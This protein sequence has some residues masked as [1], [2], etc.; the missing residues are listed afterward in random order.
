MLTGRRARERQWL[1]R[2]MRLV[3]SVLT[4]LSSN[5]RTRRRRPYWPSTVANSI[6][7]YSGP[8]AGRLVNT[9]GY[10]RRGQGSRP[11]K[12]NSTQRRSLPLGFSV[13]RAEESA[14]RNAESS[15]QTTPKIPGRRPSTREFVATSRHNASRP[16]S[17]PASKKSLPESPDSRRANPS[18]AGH[19]QEAASSKDYSKMQWQSQPV[20]N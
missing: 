18:D 20:A 4:G 2:S 19:E 5:P 8:G 3:Y 1:P 12:K 16:K 11:L 15:D 9:A 10:R 7:R 14:H 6:R 13:L 17:V